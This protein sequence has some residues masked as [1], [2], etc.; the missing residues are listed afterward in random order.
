MTTTHS[1]KIM[2]VLLDGLADRAYP[3]LGDATPLEA[4]ATPA[5]DALA[6]AGSCGF[7]YPL[8]PGLC[9][10]SYQAHFALFGYPFERFPGRGLLEAMGEGMTPAPGEVVFRANLLLAEESGTGWRVTARHDPRLGPDVLGAL[11]LDRDIDGVHVR[12]VHTGALQGLVFMSCEQ[13]LSHEVTDADPFAAGLPVLAV[14]PF[15]EAADPEAAR[16]TAD[17]ANAWMRAVAPALAVAIDPQAVAAV[18]DHTGTAAAPDAT[19]LPL[20][21]VKWAG[22]AVD[23]Q[24]FARRYGLRGATVASGPLYGGVGRVL[25]MDQVDPGFLGGRPTEDLAQRLAT[26]HRLLAEGYD[27]V[28]VHSKVPDSAGHRKDPA[29]KR[30]RIAALDKALAPLAEGIESWRD[31]LV[32]A[33]TA[34]HATPAG[35]PLYH[36]GEAVPLAVVGGTARADDVVAF[37]ERWCR[38][39]ILGQLR[40][41]DLMPVLLNAA[42]RARFLAERFTPDERYGTI[43]A[44]DL[45]GLTRE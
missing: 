22:A 19:G 28:H 10:S 40:G 43:E 23:V 15:D 45:E 33:V 25:G 30:D 41:V 26:G 12:F 17:A 5:M 3:G 32:V 37:G 16:R 39:G 24:P 6:A 36:S 34:D 2:L 44:A 21:T 20:L 18:E 14:Q 42:D 27:F 29:H 11:D 9:P 7:M 35:G 38:H 4:A 8:A 13:P 31:G 1:P